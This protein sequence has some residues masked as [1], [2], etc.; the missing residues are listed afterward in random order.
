MI[1]SRLFA[2]AALVS[3]AVTA[4]YISGIV[5]DIPIEWQTKHRVKVRGGRLES[6]VVN[7]PNSA[8]MIVVVSFPLD[9]DIAVAF[10]CRQC[11]AKMVLPETG[12]S[13]IVRDRHHG[14]FLKGLVEI[15][16]IMDS[17]LSLLEDA[18][19]AFTE[20]SD[21]PVYK[22]QVEPIVT[23]RFETITLKDE[24]LPFKPYRIPSSWRVRRSW[25]SSKDKVTLLF[26]INQ[27]TGVILRAETSGS[28]PYISIDLYNA[29]VAVFKDTMQV[30]HSDHLNQQ[31][32]RVSLDEDLLVVVC[33]A[34]SPTYHSLLLAIAQESKGNLRG[35]L[36]N[37]FPSIPYAK[38]EVKRDS[39]KQSSDKT[40]SLRPTK[41]LRLDTNRQSQW[42]SEFH[43]FD[44]MKVKCKI[45][46]DALD[47]SLLAESPSPTVQVCL[48]G[49]RTLVSTRTHGGLLVQLRDGLAINSVTIKESKFQ[50]DGSGTTQEIYINTDDIILLLVPAIA[51]VACN[52]GQIAAYFRENLAELGLPKTL[53]QAFKQVCK[54]TVLGMAVRVGSISE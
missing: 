16:F 5:P 37:T 35:P 21:L 47:V 51:N 3:T 48:K 41:R 50:H 31:D 29:A 24:I 45:E 11:I 12:V 40:K 43:I 22:I 15:M 53:E 2:T 1:L 23:E 17:Q 20:P 19:L 9:G 36:S 46:G 52:I 42:Y 34:S 14:E 33:F 4:S 10:A 7:G 13:H 6:L 26:D 32:L 54:R 8:K 44:E 39:L 28:Q 25:P 18:S 27:D 30:S 38:I 49:R